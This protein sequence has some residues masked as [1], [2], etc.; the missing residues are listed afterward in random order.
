LVD[1]QMMAD[2]FRDEPY[3]QLLGAVEGM[4]FTPGRDR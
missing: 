2:G 4:E 3:Q 1:V